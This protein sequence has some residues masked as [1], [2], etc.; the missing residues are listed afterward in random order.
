MKEEFFFKKKS[1][2]SSFLEQIFEQI[3]VFKNALRSK[4]FLLYLE[5]NDKMKEQTSWQQW[6]NDVMI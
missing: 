6:L 4:I 5:K 2:S 1:F 3:L